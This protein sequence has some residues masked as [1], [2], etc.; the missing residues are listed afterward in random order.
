MGIADPGGDIT[1]GNPICMLASRVD[2]LVGVSIPL[3]DILMGVSVP[4]MMGV[5][6]PILMGVSTPWFDTLVD[7]VDVS[8][9][10]WVDIMMGVAIPTFSSTKLSLRL[11][12]AEEGGDPAWLRLG[13]RGILIGN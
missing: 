2:I 1:E 9:S 4:I 12:L 13:L 6:V 5:S 7:I 8:G 11:C 3:I 10:R